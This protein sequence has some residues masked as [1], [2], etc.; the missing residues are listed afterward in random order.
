VL[1]R[2]RSGSLSSTDGGSG[3]VRKGS[4]REGV[5]TEEV[6]VEDEVLETGDG[7]QEAVG[8]LG[9]EGFAKGL[10]RQ[11]SL[12]SRRCEFSSHSPIA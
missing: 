3:L 1:G 12:P 11:S 10:S 9:N 7:D 4:G 2:F 8:G 6:V 5:R